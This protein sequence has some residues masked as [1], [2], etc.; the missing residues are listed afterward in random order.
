M[1]AH[2]TSTL[3][4]LVLD[5]R[6]TTGKG[7]S[8]EKRSDRELETEKHEQRKRIR[9]AT[10]RRQDIFSTSFRHGNRFPTRKPRIPC[11]LRVPRGPCRG[12]LLLDAYRLRTGSNDFPSL[13]LRLKQRVRIA[14]PR[15]QNKS[16]ALNEY[17]F[18]F[19]GCEGCTANGIFSRKLHLR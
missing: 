11:V 8:G 9:R 6:L 7:R 3:R 2:K 1:S 4:I 14:C 19:E 18:M 15:A 16:S 17:D 13:F 5:P 12:I 10:S